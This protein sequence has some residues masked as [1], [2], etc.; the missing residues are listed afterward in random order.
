M[1]CA[2]EWIFELPPRQDWNGRELPYEQSDHYNRSTFQH[3]RFAKEMARVKPSRK[4]L[5]QEKLEARSRE[6]CSEWFG[7]L[8]MAS[9]DGKQ[10]VAEYLLGQFISD[11]K[12]RFGYDPEKVRRS[13]S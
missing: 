13:I 11:M 4:R 8:A 2:P 10:Q 9:K 5:R 6:L 1:V 12:K 3:V 7:I